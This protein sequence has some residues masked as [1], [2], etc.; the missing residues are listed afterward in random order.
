MLSDRI[1]PRLKV[2][3]LAW[4]NFAVLRRSHSTEQE[5]LDTAPRVVAKQQGHSMEVHYRSYVQT[6]I[7]ELETAATKL[8]D[9]FDEVVRT[10]KT[11][12]Q[13]RD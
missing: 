3:G 9:R 12:D 4:V 2:A 11:A 7:A 6:E 1:R 5:R 10:G 8:Y 13:G